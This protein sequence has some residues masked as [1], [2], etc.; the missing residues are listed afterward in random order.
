M[1]GN[2]LRY[3]PTIIKDNFDIYQEVQTIYYKIIIFKFFYTIGH[4]KEEA[5]I[6]Q[7]V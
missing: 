7:L 4:S 1:F 5:V 3:F 2:I 6:L